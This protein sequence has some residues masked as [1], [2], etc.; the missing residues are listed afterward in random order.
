MKTPTPSLGVGAG[1]CLGVGTLSNSL[2]KTQHLRDCNS[3][4]IIIDGCT[5]RIT[6]PPKGIPRRQSFAW[7]ANALDYAERLSVEHGWPIEVKRGD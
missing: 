1:R 3:P 2:A 6:D 4:S 7:E 5:V